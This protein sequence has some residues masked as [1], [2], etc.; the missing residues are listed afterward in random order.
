MKNIIQ[1]VMLIIFCFNQILFA[2]KMPDITYFYKGEKSDAVVNFVLDYIND[3]P[4]NRQ[5]SIFPPIFGFLACIF[6]ENSNK[7]D[8][9]LKNKEFSNKG[10]Q[11]VVVF[12]LWFAGLDKKAIEYAKIYNWDNQS[13]INLRK[14]PKSI[15][16]I[17]INSPSDVDTM[18][19]VFLH[20]EIKNMLIKC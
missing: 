8:V 2:A 3:V 11:N 10:A 18:W 14:S 9:L 7:V 19:G 13:L 16:D 15:F 5:Y 1:L 12:S 20:R 17:K 4:K 6:H